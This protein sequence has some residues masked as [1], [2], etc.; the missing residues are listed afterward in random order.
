LDSEVAGHTRLRRLQ[1]VYLLPALVTGLAVGYFDT[2]LSNAALLLTSTSILTGLTFSMSATFWSRSID[3]RR[4]PQ[5]AGE[6]RVLSLLDE[7][8]N[9]LIWTVM[10]GIIST[11]ALSLVAIFSAGV[12]PVWVSAVCSFLVIYMI[13]L[14][15]GA[16]Q[17]FAEAA[18][19]L[20]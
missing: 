12:A 8:R 13:T 6:A 14:V 10:V 19:T 4:D 11:G 18:L 17:K 3:A 7:T 20:R 5:S 16:L 15:A 1:F 9:H 2:K